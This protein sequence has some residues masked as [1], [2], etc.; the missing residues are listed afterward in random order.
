[1]G[2]NQEES[3]LLLRLPGALKERL[4]A[5]AERNRRS[6]NSEIVVILSQSLCEQGSI[7]NT[8]EEK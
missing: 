7:S 5:Q 2:A 3:R 4:K 1:V 8:G 6:L